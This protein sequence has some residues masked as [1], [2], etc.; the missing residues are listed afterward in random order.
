[1]RDSVEPRPQ[2]DLPLLP[3]ECPHDLDHRVLKGIL[4]VLGFA[5]K[6]KAKAVELLLV[7]LENGG[8]R[9]PVT[10]A[11]TTREAPVGAGPHRRAR[12]PR[13]PPARFEPNRI[14]L[15]HRPVEDLR[16]SGQQEAARPL[17]LS[18]TGIRP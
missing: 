13:T 10:S 11:C 7:A 2:R 3:R 15:R 4:G 5:E 14:R 17:S 9:S 18:G 12:P 16:R 1:M 8:D 6:A